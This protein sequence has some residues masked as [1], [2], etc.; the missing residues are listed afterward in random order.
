MS[1]SFGAATDPLALL[2]F[3]VALLLNNSDVRGRNVAAAATQGYIIYSGRA[4]L[5]QKGTYKRN[6][7]L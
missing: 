2:S 4:S 7:H 6:V 1:R 3:T 5:G